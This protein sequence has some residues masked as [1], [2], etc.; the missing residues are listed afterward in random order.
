MRKIIGAVL[1]LVL[2]VWGSPA[3]A[4]SGSQA[5]EEWAR[6]DAQVN[7]DY[8][9]G[10]LMGD[11]GNEQQLLP[12]AE[13]EAMASSGGKGGD[14][15]GTGTKKGFIGTYPERKGVI[16]VTP[17]ALLGL[18]PT[19]H[20]GIVYSKNVAIEAVTWSVKELDNSWY[21]NKSQAYGVTVKGTTAKQDAKAAD[22][23]H[24]QLGKPYNVFYFNVDQRDSFYCSQLVWAAF[25][26]TASIDLN[27][28]AKGKAIHPMELVD[29]PK[30]RTIYKMRP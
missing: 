28:E 14:G 12:S 24:D 9:A 7:A 2:L 4:D 25:L 30:T 15:A 10:K 17:D 19:G 27:T 3:L 8:E 26:D 1:L 23:A 22:W 6:I 18:I 5:E 13:D 20:A 16:L 11:K 29:G 21:K